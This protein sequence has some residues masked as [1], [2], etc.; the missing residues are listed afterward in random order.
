MSQTSDDITEY[1]REQREKR[2]E[3]LL[4]SRVLAKACLDNPYQYI[5][6]LRSGEVIGFS[7]AEIIDRDWIHIK[8]D[9]THVENPLPYSAQRGVD[10]RISEIVWAVDGGH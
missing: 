10:V 5:L 7:G 2:Y 9:E 6:K 3:Q 1:E 8:I 4:G